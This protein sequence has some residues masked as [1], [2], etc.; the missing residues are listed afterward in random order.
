MKYKPRS[1][2]ATT[3]ALLM[4]NLG[5]GSFGMFAPPIGHGYYRESEMPF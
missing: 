2:G 5:V 1:L 3:L 4:A